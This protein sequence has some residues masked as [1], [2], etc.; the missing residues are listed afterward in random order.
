MDAKID[1]LFEQG[2]VEFLGPKRL[3]AQ[4][5]ERAVLHPVTGGLDF[6][7]L[8]PA[9]RPALSRLDRRCDLAGL[10]QCQWRSSSPEAKSLHGAT[11]SASPEDQAKGRT[12]N[13]FDPRS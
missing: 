13:E 1:L 6:D 12:R 7:D 8:H 11:P 10:C 9:V 5:M 2:A 4:L 3:S